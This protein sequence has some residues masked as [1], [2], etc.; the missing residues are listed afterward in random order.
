[1]EA[2]TVLPPTSSEALLKPQTAGQILV[3]ANGCIG[4]LNG[5]ITRGKAKDA[6]VEG[7]WF[8]HH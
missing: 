2:R 4:I 1:L 5:M 3:V 6:E 7:V 8:F